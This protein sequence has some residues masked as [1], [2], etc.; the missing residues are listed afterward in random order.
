MK[1]KYADRPNWKRVL[2]RKMITEKL[3]NE[4]FKGNVVLIYIEKVREALWVELG[5]KKQCVVDNGYSWLTLFPKGE[6]YVVTAMFDSRGQIVQWYIDICRDLGFTDKGIPWYD[7]LYLDV[8]V[9]SDY[10]VS[11][12]DEDDLNLALKQNVI[13]QEDFDFAYV[14]ANKLM[15]QLSQ[16]KLT[17]LDYSKK[18]YKELLKRI[19]KEK[20][21][22]V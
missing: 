11:L 9:S 20:Q 12:I 15:E 19:E 16:N 2:S 10:H 21:R 14:E 8:I 6:S 7:D 13:R 18:I 4:E 3:D 22:K 1:R 17:I 5:G